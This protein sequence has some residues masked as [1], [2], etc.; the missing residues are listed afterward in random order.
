MKQS[1]DIKS[2]GVE[3]M[4]DIGRLIRHVGARDSVPQERFDRAK[5]NVQRHWEGVVAEQ[6]RGRSSSQ[7]RFLAIAASIVAA[8]AVSLFL[9]YSGQAPGPLAMASVDRVLGEVRIAG[10]PVTVGNV[11]DPDTLIETAEGGR[12]ALR[13]AAGQSLRID[14][15]SRV[16]LHTAS[17]MTLDAGGIYI[18]TEQLA[19]ATPVRVM[20]HLGEARDVG[21]QFQVRLTDELLTVGV[22][23]GKVELTR[24]D[25]DTLSIGSGFV[26]DLSSRGDQTERT[27][28]PD[29]PIWQWVE[30]VAPEF[31][32]DGATLE[33][34]LDW[35]AGQKGLSLAWSDAGSEAQAK[36]TRLRGSIAGTTLEDGFEAVQRIAKFEY[37]FEDDVLWVTLQ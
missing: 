2:N 12:I 8:I 11:V 5:V 3:E 29:D 26:L 37:R 6:R 32:L 34:Y 19:S 23:E 28:T 35:Y 1:D 25:Q 18:D 14:S 31:E 22:R 16:V 24:P 4:D 13:L 17:E 36:R 7:L 9:T 10:A 27:A 30:A 20:T 33:Q 15:R 21:T